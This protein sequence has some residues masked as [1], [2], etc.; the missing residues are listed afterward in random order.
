[1]LIF[2]SLDIFLNKITMYRLVLYVLIFLI[3][4]ALILSSLGHFSFTSYALLY[5]VVILLVVSFITHK[6][7]SKIFRVQTNIESTYITALILALIID[8]P[9]VGHYY[10][11]LSILIWAG[12]WSVAVKYIL[13]ISKKHIFNP[14]AI[15]VVITSLAIHQ[16]A[17]WWVGHV[18][19]LPFVLVGGLL[20]V[21]KIKR[22][23]L[24]ISFLVIAVL[25][26]IIGSFNRSN[27]ITLLQQIFIDSPL[28]FFAFVMLT[29]PLTTPPTRKKRILYGAFTGILYAPFIHLGPIFSTPELALCTGNIFSWLLSPKSKYV[30]TLKSKNKIARDTGEFVFSPNRSISF[31]PGQYLEW[32]LDHKHPDS[33][34]NRRYFTIASSPTENNILLG[35]KFNAKRSSS[36]KTSLAELEEGQT[37][38][39][40]QL[41]G[42]F[43]LPKDSKKKLCFIAGGIGI[44]PFRSMIAYM[45]DK[46]EQRDV[47][48]IYSCKRFDDLA[49]TNLIHHAHTNFG[50]KTVSTLTDLDHLPPDWAG[51]KG[52]ISVELLLQEV[53]DY[54]ER[55][56][57]ISGP[58]SLV[59]AT[60]SILY[61]IGVKNKNIKTDYFPGF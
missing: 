42:D 53:P 6:L 26:I 37:I 41:S 47:V 19:M 49:Y 29:E 52:F 45:V 11:V 40:G 46:N 20:I 58:P 21:K 51:Y 33:R 1:M 44:T 31:K 30:L 9:M 4:I 57:Y 54:L 24:V 23:D 61:E 3:G 15:A 17:S 35:V 8:P 5:S 56:F 27:L 18:W 60:E 25:T 16:S 12:I 10:T 59:S 48:L 43:V 22:F 38:V 50:L 32:T 7:F 14:A 55:T 39:A 2:R 34:G 28:F 36:F 13:V